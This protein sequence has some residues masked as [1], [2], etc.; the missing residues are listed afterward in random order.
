MKRVLHT[1]VLAIR[2]PE[3]DCDV[4]RQQYGR[5][6]EDVVAVETIRFSDFKPTA[7]RLDTLLY[8]T[9]ACNTDFP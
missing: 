5:Y 9:M 7:S 8:Q 3:D 1:L 6:L 4:I 2:L